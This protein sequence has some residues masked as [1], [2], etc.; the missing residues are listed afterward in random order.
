[1]IPLFVLL[2]VMPFLE[3]NHHDTLIQGDADTMQVMVTDS[4]GVA[5][6]SVR[7]ELGF[8]DSGIIETG[9]TVLYTDSRGSAYTEIFARNPGYTDIYVIAVDNGDTAFDTTGVLVLDS[10]LYFSISVYP[11]RMTV[12]SDETDTVYARLYSRDSIVA[13]RPIQFNVVKGSGHV[14]PL[15]YNTDIN[16]LAYT[17]F[18]PYIRDTV[19][20]EGYYEDNFGRRVSDTTRIVVN[21]S[22]VD[23]QRAFGDSL[24]FYPSPIGHGHDRANIEYLLPGNFTDVEIRILD[25]FGNTVFLKR[26]KPGETGGTQGAWNRIQW[27][28]TNNNGKKVASG[29]Y[30][31]VVRIYRGTA[32][33]RELSRRV[34]VEW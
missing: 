11:A 9:D 2:T 19:F 30:I 26:I 18:Y 1:M 33:L 10:T 34:G 15:I 23:T 16:G 24:F 14:A 28:G 7:I 25:P 12:S 29:M 22:A 6:D 21:P 32:L 3:I 31:L 4:Q 17:V 5:L 20:V 13:G 8:E 27:D